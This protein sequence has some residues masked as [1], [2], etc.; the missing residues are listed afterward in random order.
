MSLKKTYWNEFKQTLAY[1]VLSGHH[2]PHNGSA[3]QVNQHQASGL[4]LKNRRIRDLAISSA[5][6]MAGTR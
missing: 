1:P 4:W 2:D 5:Q 6:A 3:K